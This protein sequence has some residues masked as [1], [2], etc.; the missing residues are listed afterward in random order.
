MITLALD[1]G[2]K[3]IG[4]AIS[5]SGVVVEPVGV[6]QAKPVESFLTQLKELTQKE[7]V[8]RIVVGLPESASKNQK[9]EFQ[10]MAEK[11]FAATKVPVSEI[12]EDF[13]TEEAKE[14]TKSRNAA[15]HEDAAAAQIILERFLEEL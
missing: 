4:V 3:N 12:E 2:L 7:K 13:S 11:I 14:R 1:L 6:W 15:A 10:K 5:R 8:K 9:K